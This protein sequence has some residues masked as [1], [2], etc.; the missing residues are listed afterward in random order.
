M[1]RS[2]K[3]LL[4]PTKG[5]ARRLDH[6]LWQQR[7]LYNAALE[8]R[9]TAWENEQRCVTRYQQFAGLNG[10]AATKADLAHYGTCVARGTLTRLDLAYQAFFRRCRSGEKPG[11]PRF[12]G[13]YRWD[14][15]SYPDSSGWKLDPDAHRLYLLGVGQVKAKLHRALPGRPKTAIVKREGRRW[16]VV[17]QCDQVP[18]RPL[19]ATGR[20]VGID[21][22]VASLATTSLG[23][24]LANPRFTRRAAARL[25]AAQRELATKQRGSAR[26]RKAVQRVAAQHRRVA[27]S[28]RDLAHQLSRKLVDGF[29]V[30]VHEDLAIPNMVRSARGTVDQPGTNVAAKAGLNRSIADAGWGQLLRFLA[31][32]AEDAGREL[33]AV[34][35]RN[36]SRTCSS[37]GH[38]EKDNRRVQAV[39]RC[40]GCG[41]EAH[42]DENAA[43][44]I[45]RAGLAL[46]QQQRAAQREAREVAA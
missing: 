24:H 42:A 2:A 39:F 23:E 30:I 1:N 45:L 37:C 25:A 9:K 40:L 44:N 46:R 29:D 16:W 38:C 5:Q 13:R 12:K 19:P 32:K 7:M 21:L 4:Q 15:V 8:E 11:H 10:M 36:T 27:N 3:Y 41:H 34:D 14:S 35:P 6:L 20:K 33:I 18:A 22:G 31:Y 28:R 26:R 43:V 17:V